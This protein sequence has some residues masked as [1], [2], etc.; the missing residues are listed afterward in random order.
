M[1]ERKRD[2]GVPPGLAPRVAVSIVVFFVWLI[3]TIIHMAFFAQSFSLL[4]NIAIIF[5]VFLGGV[6]ILAVVWSSWGIKMGK[7]WREE[8]R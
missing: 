5:S 7:R 6:M 3:Y 8:R 4:Q 2:R 1:P